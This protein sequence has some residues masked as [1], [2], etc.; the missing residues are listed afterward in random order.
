LCSGQCAHKQIV[1]QALAAILTAGDK[2]EYALDRNDPNYD[3]E[4]ERTVV[5]QSA[6]N[7]KLRDDVTAYKD[8]VCV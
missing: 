2:A 4:E 3:S 6:Q 5:L 7:Q 8:E 1:L